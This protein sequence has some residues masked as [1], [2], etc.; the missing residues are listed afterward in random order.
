MRHGWASYENGLPTAV[1]FSK[2]AR[3][4]VVCPIEFLPYTKKPPGSTK[5]IPGQSLG[6]DRAAWIPAP[7]DMP[8]DAEAAG[9]L[10]PAGVARAQY[11]FLIPIFLVASAR[12]DGPFPPVYRQLCFPAHVPRQ[13]SAAFRSARPLWRQ[14]E[15]GRFPG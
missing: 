14:L 11:T 12:I 10:Q 8:P 15:S 5:M 13:A 2:T 1:H 9:Y 3:R 4:R 7:G 6:R